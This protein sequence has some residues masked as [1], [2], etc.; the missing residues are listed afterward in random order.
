M[1][2]LN[3][4][5]LVSLA[6][7]LLSAA[8][9]SVTAAEPRP[10]GEH[11]HDPLRS[12]TASRV[13]FHR[14]L[15]QAAWH[16]PT[17]APARASRAAAVEL[18]RHA[19]ALFVR[20]PELTVTAGPRFGAET[21][22]D[23]SAT[24][25]QPIALGAVGNARSRVAAARRD[26]A[27]A[28]F[29]EA[30]ARSVLAAGTAWIEARVA[31]ELV[32][33]RNDGLR[34]A[35]A[36]D[37]LAESKLVSGVATAGERALA[38]SLLGSARAALLDAEGRRFVAGAEL[39]FHLGNPEATVEPSGPL[40]DDGPDVSE[41]DALA[42]AARHPRLRRLDAEARA[43]AELSAQS[44]AEG[45]PVLSVGPSVT[46]EGNGDVI[47]LGHVSVPLPFVN[48]NEFEAAER[49]RHTLLVRAEL[50]RERQRL[51]SEVLIA[52]H[53]RLHA[54]R[55]RDALT[56]D[57]MRPARVALDEATRRYDEG[58]APLGEVLAARR[59]LTEVEERRIEAA[60]AARLAE[61]TLLFVMDRLVPE[62]S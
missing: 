24:L 55:V 6:Y 62:A 7:V 17:L 22:L 51:R 56:R 38:R 2:W 60:G 33:V 46:R 18:E 57:G 14:A 15:Q 47:V 4:V 8:G 5:A 48:P 30:R 35:E 16:A 13:T 61:I 54:R 44:R 3:G 23:A 19:R 9:S 43:F 42:K 41:A 27:R 31:A 32:R 28:E 20:P 50:T 25:L 49:G 40:E 58:K 52:L 21:G 26:A 36:L 53:E 10:A 59:A 12:P 45:G 34:E 39:A 37:G 1:E 11:E 29:D